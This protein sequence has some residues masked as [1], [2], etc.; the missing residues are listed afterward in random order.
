MAGDVVYVN[1]VLTI[2][3]ETAGSLTKVY[4]DKIDKY[5]LP[6]IQRHIDQQRHR[7]SSQE[8][9]HILCVRYTS[10]GRNLDVWQGR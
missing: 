7:L 5:M 2:V 6:M 8:I 4:A 10:V 1:G 3:H 9:K